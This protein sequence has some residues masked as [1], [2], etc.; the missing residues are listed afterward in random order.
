MSRRPGIGYDWYNEHFDQIYEF[1]KVVF[2]R[3]DKVIYQNP[4]RYVDRMLRDRDEQRY[5][6]L[7]EKRHQDFYDSVDCKT[8]ESVDLAT[9]NHRAEQEKLRSAKLLKRKI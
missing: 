8:Y 1:D 3:G 4:V 7:K 9:N 2:K 6:D 5:Y